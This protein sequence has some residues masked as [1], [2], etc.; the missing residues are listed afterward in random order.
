MASGKYSEAIRAEELRL[1]ASGLL[2]NK[3]H[4]VKEDITGKSR[5]ELLGKLEEFKRL[6]D[7]RMKDVTGEVLEHQDIVPDNEDVAISGTTTGAGGGG[8]E[9]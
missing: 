8:E 4:I 3:Q 1:K 6:A 7:S 5:D 9:G 2:I